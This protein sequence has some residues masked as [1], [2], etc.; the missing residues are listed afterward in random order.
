M[1]TGGAY[2]NRGG[3]EEALPKNESEINLLYN[4]IK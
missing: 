4:L 1:T 3:E 2:W